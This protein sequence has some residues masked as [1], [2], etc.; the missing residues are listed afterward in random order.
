MGGCNIFSYQRRVQYKCVPERAHATI[1]HEV[2][3]L[4]HAASL[5]VV[6]G[7]VVVFSS[8]PLQHWDDMLPVLDDSLCDKKCRKYFCTKIFP[9]SRNR[10]SDSIGHAS[11][12]HIAGN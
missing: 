10:V 12:W 9:I 7:A 3:V 11:D 8:W 2:P 5:S 1:C 4:A 6:V